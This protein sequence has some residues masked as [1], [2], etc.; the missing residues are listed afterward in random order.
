MTNLNTI[1]PAAVAGEA[2]IENNDVVIAKSKY[3]KSCQC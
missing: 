1:D 3:Y 2:K